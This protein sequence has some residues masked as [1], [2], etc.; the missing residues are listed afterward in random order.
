MCGS[1]RSKKA[2]RFDKKGVCAGTASDEEKVL[3]A[4]SGER[5]R[6]WFETYG[7]P[8]FCHRESGGRKPRYFCVA[9]CECR[10]GAGREV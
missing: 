3:C 9:G 4:L 7:D 10:G 1:K 8:F 5:Q 6:F 2:D